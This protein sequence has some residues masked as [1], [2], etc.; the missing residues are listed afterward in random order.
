MT[1]FMPR[2]SYSCATRG[3]RRLD[4]MKICPNCGEDNPERARFCITCGSE[5]PAEEATRFRKVITLLFCDLIDGGELAE[6]LE[7]GDLSQA[8]GTYYE[9][10]RPIIEGHGGTVAKFIG[11]AIMSV[12][13]VPVL[14]EDDALRAS[15]AALD[16]RA[17]LV[18]VNAEL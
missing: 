5:L 12:F 4:R 15:R 2:G 8:L 13:G 17:R 18:D 3:K 10:M 11:D 6:R 7:P 1:P 16:M 9:A 14:H